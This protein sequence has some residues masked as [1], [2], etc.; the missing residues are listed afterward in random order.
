MKLLLVLAVVLFGV[1]FW[2]SSRGVVHQRPKKQEPRAMQAPLEMV[3]CALCS[4]H[5]SIADAIPGKNGFYCCL[6]HRQR[7][8]R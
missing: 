4:V 6:D 5:V 7:A 8:E 3:G 2:R 1:W